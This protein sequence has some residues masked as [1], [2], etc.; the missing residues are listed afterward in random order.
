MK[1]KQKRIN[2]CEYFC[3]ASFPGMLSAIV[4]FTCSSF[5]VS[6]NVGEVFRCRTSFSFLKSLIITRLCFWHI[7]CI[8]MK[9]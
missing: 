3:F 4:C 1:K 5:I 2:S 7:T 6:A 8:T 9:E